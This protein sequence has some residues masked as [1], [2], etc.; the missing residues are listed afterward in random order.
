[1]HIPT[2]PHTSPYSTMKMKK[3]IL[4]LLAAASLAGSANAAILTGVT[5]V[6]ANTMTDYSGAALLSFDFDMHQLS[7]AS[8]HYLIEDADLLAP[9][10]SFNALVRNFTGHGISQFRFSV[11]GTSYAG[12]GSV[13][14]T[15]GVLG[16]VGWNGGQANLNFSSPE[17]A[18][19]HFGNPL[20]VPG[21]MDWRLSTQG[22]RA[23]DGVTITA[24]VP[25]PGS[26]P[27]MVAALALLAF[28][29]W[30]ANSR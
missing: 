8:L 26:T 24:A 14:P 19:F 3:H 4:A 30:R 21:R 10:L 20:A 6:G 2:H 11:T 16:N 7:G 18:E 13:T 23:G 1:M 27:L 25:E 22:L 12:M 5:G 28:T 9:Y 17:W 29:R 15:F